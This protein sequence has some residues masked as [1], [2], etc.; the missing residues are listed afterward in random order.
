MCSAYNTSDIILK[1]RKA[2]MILSLPKPIE[3][4]KLAALLS[5]YLQQ[6]PAICLYIN[7][8]SCSSSVFNHR[9]LSWCL[10]L[11][12]LKLTVA[13]LSWAILSRCPW[14]LLAKE[15]SS[16]HLPNSHSSKLVANS[17][18]CTKLQTARCRDFS[19]LKNDLRFQACLFLRNFSPLN[20]GLAMMFT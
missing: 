19:Y 1:A 11:L 18:T 12:Q 10:L 16:R 13:T 4:S 14:L 7:I 9:H 5:T 17:L 6:W 15:S 8:N 20:P 2:G 3:S